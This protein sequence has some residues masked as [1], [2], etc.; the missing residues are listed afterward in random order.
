MY[1]LSNLIENYIYN[2]KHFNKRVN[3]LYL[4]EWVDYMLKSGYK[5]PSLEKFSSED[6]AE[7]SLIMFEKIINELD[8]LK[9]GGFSEINE[10]F[11]YYISSM[12]YINGCYESAVE[13]LYYKWHMAERLCFPYRIEYCVDR[14]CYY[15]KGKSSDELESF[16]V[17]FLEKNMVKLIK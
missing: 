12:E 8:L 16:S 14:D 1:L 13:F 2:R 11:L 5:S 4:S 3:Y 15:A 7:I 6:D 10:D 17:E 9:Y